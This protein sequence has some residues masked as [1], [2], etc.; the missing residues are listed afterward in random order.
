MSE[1]RFAVPG[2]S[3]APCEVCGDPTINRI[4]IGDGFAAVCSEFCL[5]AWPATFSKI[6]TIARLEREAAEARKERDDAHERAGQCAEDMVL[7]QSE[8]D[9]ARAVLKRVRAKLD[10]EI[11]S[12]QRAVDGLLECGHGS[13]PEYE[14]ESYVVR[15]LR[16]VRRVMGGE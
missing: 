6:D 5:H 13:S 1:L 8:R 16:S 9:E 7:A 2:A 10:H 12:H 15:E 11:T 14:Q 4:E 3:D